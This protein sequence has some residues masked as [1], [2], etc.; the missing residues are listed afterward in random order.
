MMLTKEDLKTL[1]V[2]APLIAAVIAPLSTL[3]DIPALAEPWFFQYHPESGTLTKLPDPPTNIT[4]SGVSLGFNVLANALLIV[5]FSLTE[6]LWQHSTNVSLVCWI[7][8]FGIAFGNVLAFGILSRNTPDVSYGEGFW[9]AV[10]SLLLATVILG[11]LLLHFF[12]VFAR[13]KA[14]GP[15]SENQI[16]VRIAGR[17]F[18]IQN[19]LFVTTIGLLALYMS[20]LEYWT[21]LQGIYFAIVSVLT[22]GFGDFY[23]TKV[24]TQIVLFPFVLVAIVQLVSI[25]DML[26]RF[27]RGRLAS[28]RAERRREFERRRQEKENEIEKE[29][30]LEQELEFLS[31]LYHETDKWKTMQDLVASCIGFIIFWLLG[32]VI[33]SQIESWTY[34]EGLYFCYVFFLTI[35]YG[36]YAP[37][38]PAGRVVFIVYSIIAVPIMASLA[39]QAV[40]GVFQKFSAEVLRKHEAKAGVGQGT[41]PDRNRE[42]A[43]E[44]ANEVAFDGDE[45][46][47]LPQDIR[48]KLRKNDRMERFKRTHSHFIAAEQ[49]RIN[50]E[51]LSSRPNNSEDREHPGGDNNEERAEE[52]ELERQRNEDRILTESILELA[53]ELEKHARRLLLGHMDEGSSA[54]LL[55]KADRIVQLR[56]IKALA[57]QE[58]S[59]DQD[60]SE[61]M[62]GTSSGQ[63]SGDAS[64]S[65][66]AG[67]SSR[68]NEM[69]RK[70]YEEEAELLPFPTDLDEEE[71]LEEVTRYREAF[72]GLLAVGSRLLKL[73]DEE[74][75]LFERRYWKRTVDER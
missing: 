54:R 62:D 23:P 14:R 25:I 64:A 11:L 24:A 51:L 56:N 33:F 48:D 65:R 45:E 46:K 3:L 61:Q 73:K 53:V 69:M 55:L 15:P 75:F 50:A 49:K 47:T 18:M 20:R 6:G 67:A 36:D 32:A 39:V 9:S 28:R 26:I 8:K 30:N 27:F 70:Y 29:P 19:T 60:T 4:L 7:V 66:K 13:D 31:R 10:M 44:V 58:Q 2:F 42:V 68:V 37:V 59:T 38:T 74:K 52:S 71:T 5:R 63:Q 12:L 72:A 21:Y 41:I 43:R 34:G 1:P 57:L 35:G 22:V 17:H 16:R 40:E